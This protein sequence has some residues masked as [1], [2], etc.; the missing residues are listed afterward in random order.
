MTKAIDDQIAR[1]KELGDQLKGINDQKID[2]KFQGGQIGKGELNKQ[3]AEIQE[4]ARKAGLSASRSFAAS[5]G[6]DELTPEKAKE[7]ADGLA[8]IKQGFDDIAIAQTANLE[9]SREWAAGWSEAY[10]N[11]S[12]NASNSAQNAKTVFETATKGMEDAIV[13][14]AMTGKL[15]FRDMA[16]AIIADI[17]RIMARKAILSAMGLGGGLFGFAGGGLVDSGKPYMVGEQGPELFVPT[18]AGNI[19][20]NHQLGAGG[21]ETNVVYNIQAVDASSFRSLVA[22][23]PQFIYNI[24][25]VG[26]KSTPSRRFA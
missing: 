17:V 19:V 3:F 13:N 26:R 4:N 15:S 18:S 8:L 25:E 24:T 20:P 7:L 21:R 23:D 11:Y 9:K 10:Q 5:F 16:N 22:R 2:L 6:E 14:F 12:D 1:G